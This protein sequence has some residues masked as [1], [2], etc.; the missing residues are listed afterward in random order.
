MSDFDYPANIARLHEGRWDIDRAKAWH[1][2]LPWLVGSNFVPSTASNQL[3][4]WQAST[5]DPVTI[6]R[7]LGWAAAIGM[8]SMRVFLHDLAWLQDPAGFLARMD[9]YLTIAH[10]HGIHTL[11][12]FFD[13]CWHPFP[14]IGVQREPE[15][16]VHNSCWLQSPGVEALRDPALF[17]QLRPY[18]TAVVERFRNDLRI[19]GWDVWN[20]PD[21][22]NHA[23]R[24]PRDLGDRKWTWVQPLLVEAFGWIRAVAPSQP[25]TCGIWHGDYSPGQLT[26]YQQLQVEG[27]DIISFHRYEDGAATRLRVEQIAGFGRPLWCTEFM[28]RG[29]NSTFAEVLPVLQERKVGAWCWGL[30]AGRSQTNYPWDSW[31]KSYPAD[32]PPLWFHEVFR[33]DGSPYRADEVAVIRQ[34]TAKR[35]ATRA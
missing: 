11:F 13:S 18:V 24:G 7:E 29:V 27:S 9:Q 34:L 21:N 33:R 17:A 15:P 19:I 32:E 4:M 14:R 10:R 2:R 20:E 12:V 22:A 35:A 5:F 30:V 25:L 28:A 31:Q 8:N 6:E 3:E 23:S 16:G 26:G 1:D